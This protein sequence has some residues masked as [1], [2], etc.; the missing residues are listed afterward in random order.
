LCVVCAHSI[1]YEIM[2]NLRS[3]LYLLA[4]LHL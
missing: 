2:S 4:P 3:A 1:Y